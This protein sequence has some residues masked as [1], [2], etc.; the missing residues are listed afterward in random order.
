MLGTVQDLP[1]PL[2]PWPLRWE[3][4]GMGVTQFARSVLKG[5]GENSINSQKYIYKADTGRT[6]KRPKREQPH[7][8][9]GEGAHSKGYQC[10]A[11]ESEVARYHP[12]SWH[13]STAD[14]AVALVLCHGA[15]RASTPLGDSPGPPPRPQPCLIQTQ[16]YVS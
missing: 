13:R 9:L 5:G 12:K 14:R 3:L 6:R 1:P 2:P 4:R 7:G 15:H 11:A 10:G 8:A 16:I